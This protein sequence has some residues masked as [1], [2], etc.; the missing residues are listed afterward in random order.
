MSGRAVKSA[1][2]VIE[3]MELFGVERRP[4]S[5]TEIGGV[6]GYPKSSVSGLLHTLVKSGWLSQQVET[7]LY[8]PTLRVASLGEWLPSTLVG[9]S[10]TDAI[11]L[12]LQ[13]KT[14]ETVTLSIPNGVYMEFIRIHMGLAH[15]KILDVSSGTKIPMFG[16]ALG[17]AY[18]QTQSDAGIRRHYKRAEQENALSGPSRCLQDYILEIKETQ[19]RGYSVAYDRIGANTGAISACLSESRI[20]RS[21]VLAIGGLSSQISQNERSYS[22]LIRQAVLLARRQVSAH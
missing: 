16:T 12:D 2:R 20:G 5:A 21:V 4:M 15:P 7:M 18:L 11:A 8:H 3:V 13:N 6:L 9:G 17:T 19:A 22:K 1:T 14:R 10:S